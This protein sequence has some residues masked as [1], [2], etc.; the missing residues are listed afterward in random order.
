MYCRH[1]SDNT[2]VENNTISENE[3]GAFIE[4]SSKSI[5]VN[6]TI[7]GN[8]YGVHLKYSTDSMLV[9]NNFVDNGLVISGNKDKYWRHDIA[10]DNLV[11]G[12]PMGYFWNLLGGVI[13]GTQYGQVIL[14]N[15]VG[16]TVEDGT[17][18]NVTFGIL[19]GYSS[20][21]NLINNIINIS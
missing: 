9:S 7:I 6:N 5:V 21:C 16:V 2:L 11:N 14:G 3:F 12:K 1:L 19:M 18:N 10:I 20:H 13:D 17:F 4:F 15:C 8:D